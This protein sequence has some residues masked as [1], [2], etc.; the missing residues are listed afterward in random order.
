MKID[1][2]QVI[3]KEMIEQKNID[4]IKR[5]IAAVRYR[6]EVKGIKV[7][8]MVIDTSRDSQ[9]MITA[10]TLSAMIDSTYVCRWKTPDGFF[11]LDASALLE[12]SQAMRKHVQL[13]FDREDVLVKAVDAG[14]YTESM[15][16]EGWPSA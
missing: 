6:F 1:F 4:E 3:T 14:T 16:Q 9:A 13:C 8:G 15:L 7:N 5:D 2:N 10:A 11:T 12:V